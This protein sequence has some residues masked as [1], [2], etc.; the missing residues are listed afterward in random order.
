MYHVY[1]CLC[2]KEIDENDDEINFGTEATI[3]L[4]GVSG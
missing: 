1:F 4:D 2:W 3:D